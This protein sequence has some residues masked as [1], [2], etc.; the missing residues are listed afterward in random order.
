MVVTLL[1]LPFV[2]VLFMAAVSASVGA[3]DSKS[4]AWAAAV[5]GGSLVALAGV[6]GLFSVDAN[7]GTLAFVILG[8]APRLGLWAGRVVVVSVLSMTVS[9][10]DLGLTWPFTRA[11]P[12]GTDLLQL[13]LVLFVNGFA[14]SIFS[15]ALGSFAVRLKDPLTITNLAGYALTVLC[16]VVAPLSTLPSWLQVLARALPLTEG[17][18][19]TRDIF[20]GVTSDVYWTLL[21]EIGV[22][23]VWLAAGELFW[24]HSVRAL[25]MHA[26]SELS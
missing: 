13:I 23:L 16:G 14:V 17:I 18:S 26:S 15:V 10:V 22:A 2:G 24:T 3:A 25:R 8:G 21:L 5:Q 4:V 1:V 6:G 11:A 20:Q 7:A 9:V 19:A 12:D